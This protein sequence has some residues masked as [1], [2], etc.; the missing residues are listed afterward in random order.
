MTH[1]VRTGTPEKA[2][3]HPVEGPHT[4]VHPVSTVRAQGRSSESSGHPTPTSGYTPRAGSLWSAGASGRTESGPTTAHH[5]RRGSGRSRGQPQPLV[6]GET[7]PRDPTVCFDPVR[8]TGESGGGGR[9]GGRWPWWG[10]SGLERDR[11]RG[12]CTV[13]GGVRSGGPV[14]SGTGRR[15]SPVLVWPLGCRGVSTG[16]S[17]RRGLKDRSST[18]GCREL[19][20][21]FVDT[22]P[23]VL[24]RTLDRPTSLCHRGV[25]RS[26]RT[27]SGFRRRT[28]SAASGTRGCGGPFQGG[29]PTRKDNP[30]LESPPG[31]RE[32]PHD[33]KSHSPP[34][35]RGVPQDPKSTS[36]QGGFDPVVTRGAFPVSST[37]SRGLEGVVQV[38]PVVRT[39]TVTVQL[40]RRPSRARSYRGYV[41]HKRPGNPRTHAVGGRPLPTITPATDVLKGF[42]RLRTISSG[43]RTNRWRRGRPSPLI[44][45]PGA[46]R[47]STPPPPG[48]SD[49]FRGS[50]PATSAYLPSSSGRP[51]SRSRRGDTWYQVATDDD[52]TTPRD[53][54]RPLTPAPRGL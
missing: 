45:R 31:S 6:L 11:G 35:S 49:I 36:S 7:L 47:P 2:P 54:S 16:S 28:G 50:W 19:P 48:R 3:V 42:F 25:R 51:G 41:P 14:G 9:G 40:G 26:R 13:H 12:V 43:S 44:P 29:R 15:T 23:E 10:Y 38:G 37:G 30:S 5:P 52:R 33:P 1:T 34:G 24:V 39:P 27:D 4:R 46:P 21:S 22:S 32:V 20:P 53:E 18:D 8:T 17:A